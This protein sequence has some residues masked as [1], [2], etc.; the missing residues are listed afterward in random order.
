MTN[1]YNRNLLSSVPQDTVVQLLKEAISWL[2]GNF[3][4]LGL[5]DTLKGSISARLN[6]RL[7]MLHAVGSDL[8]CQ[9]PEHHLRWESVSKCVELVSSTHDQAIRVEHAFSGK[10]QRQLASTTPPRPIIN[11][12]FPEAKEYFLRLCKHGKE[13]YGILNCTQPSVALVSQVRNSS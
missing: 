1:L 4:L 5:N 9:M 11:L 2:E 6:L 8:S 13:V 12:T 7:N 10:I 3:S